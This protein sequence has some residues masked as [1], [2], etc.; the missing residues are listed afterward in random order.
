M[1]VLVCFA[2]PLSH[3]ST[4][5]STAVAANPHKEATVRAFNRDVVTLRSEL[6]GVSA[7]DRAR[8][9]SARIME[10]L[11]R[12]GNLTVSIKTDPAGQLIQI[13]GQTAFMLTPADINPV[14]EET[15]LQASERAS[16]AIETIIGEHRESQDLK[17]MATS[18]LVAAGFTLMAWILWWLTRK[19]LT[20]IEAK[21][22]SLVSQHPNGYKLAGVDVLDAQKV[23]TSVHTL[24]LFFKW[25]LFS[26]YLYQWLSLT[27]AVFPYTRAWGERLNSYLWDVVF[28][29]ASAVANSVPNLFVAIL[30]FLISFW[31]TRTLD[32]M[33]LR[34]SSGSLQV[35]WLESD[36]AEPT[37]KITKT[38]IWLFAIAMAYPYIPG[39]QTQA[40]QGL[41][42]LLGLMLSVG[43]S[44][45]VGQGASGLI[46]TY[47]RVFRPGEFVRIGD[48]EGT[49]VELGMFTTRI[50]TGLGEE[51]TISNTTV[52]A[53]NTKNYSRAVKGNGFV[54]DT[55]VT[56]GYDTPWRQVHAMLEE[57]ARATDGILVDPAPKVF[58][59]SLED[60]YPR[61]RLV[62]QAVPSA[63][64]PRA[65]I[66]SDLHANI[67]DT[68]NRYG[69]QIMS[70][71]YIMDPN[72]P[73]VVP[74]EKWYELPA[75]K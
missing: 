64:G 60:W 11:E 26:V 66:L 74:P 59:T 31:S 4:R 3:A 30:I 56:I 63:P 29:F 65:A 57:A 8:R 58:Q 23:L 21:T 61:Y 36:I 2:L 33:F 41:S 22:S 19:G 40:F 10:L 6:L 51:L 9:A 12:G 62:C 1:V 49:V 72:H 69:V 18:A 75:K 28:H 34:I 20:K 54:L 15:L 27:L 55:E 35:N 50:R 45:I 24:V 48:Y 7:E 42:V 44:N 73:K 52:L 13:D 39:S 68:F 47:G 38:V 5:V 46:L 71:Q 53:T 14:N 70:P 16:Q 32:R 17:Q 25:I 67:Q 37:R 43:A